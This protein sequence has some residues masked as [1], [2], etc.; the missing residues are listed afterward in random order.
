[1]GVAANLYPTELP[2]G[3][4]FLD[5]E[6]RFDPAQHLALEQPERVLMLTEL[7]YSETQVHK[8]AS[9]VAA[10]SP[11]RV[12]SPDGVSAALE[13]VEALCEDSARQTDGEPPAVIFNASCR[14][15]F[16]RDLCLDE[17]VASF[18]SRIFRTG[19]MPHSMLHLQSQLNLAPRSL[20]EDGFGWHHDIAAFSYVLMLHDPAELDGGRFEYFDGTREEA[21]ELLERDGDLP[22]DRLVRPDYPGPGYACFM[23]GSAISHRGGPMYSPGFRAAL[24]HS[25]CS[26]ELNVSDPNRVIFTDDFRDDPQYARYKAMDWARHNAWRSQ[27]K[28]RRVLEEMP[29]C[30]DAE[31]IAVSLYEAIAETAQAAAL[32]RKGFL[33]PEEASRWCQEKD[34]EMMS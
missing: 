15:R 30:D 1:M 12:L 19:L 22:Q 34:R 4:R 7:G 2:D 29:Y 14:S 20:V 8:Y 5:N 33:T 18:F 21:A 13:V 26:T 24:V 31:K 32:I 6:P 28:L 27:E 10:T 3:F 23:Q 9:P 11:V 17:S 25:Y 16:F